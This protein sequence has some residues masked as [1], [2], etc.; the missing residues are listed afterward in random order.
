MSADPNDMTA[1]TSGHF[2][3][4]DPVTATINQHA[5]SNKSNLLTRWKLVTHLKSEFWNRWSSEYLQQLQHRY[6]WKQS[7]HDIIVSSWYDG[8]CQRR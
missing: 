1:L 3:I 5:T 8:H 4:G 7:S 6:K 2:L